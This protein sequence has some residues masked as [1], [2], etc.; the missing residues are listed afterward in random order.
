MQ[1]S[2]INALT[3]IALSACSDQKP[4]NL[5]TAT[6][7]KLGLN[8]VAILIPYHQIPALLT[9]SPTINGEH[10]FVSNEIL[11]QLSKIL[12]SDQ[13]LHEKENFAFGKTGDKAFES[14][15]TAPGK[16]SGESPY[17]LVSTRIDPCVNELQKSANDTCEANI[18]L[19]F[20]PL[21]LDEKGQVFAKDSNIHAIYHIEAKEFTKIVN[22]LKELR[23]KSPAVAQ[24]T[25]SPHPIIAKEG[26]NSPYFHA[27]ISLLQ[28]HLSM[29]NLKRIAF[30]GDTDPTRQGHW[31]M[32]AFNI[33]NQKP[34]LVPLDKLGK[35]D[36]E[37]QKNVQRLHGNHEHLEEPLP[38][39]DIK[40][41]LFP[42]M[43]LTGKE[44]PETIQNSIKQFMLTK[45][46]N[47]FKLDNP[48]LHDP[49]T[50]DCASCHV[51]EIQ[52]SQLLPEVKGLGLELP[53]DLGFRSQHFNLKHNVP[54]DFSR[55]SLQIFSYF[56]NFP[57]ISQRAVNDA[58]HSAELINQIP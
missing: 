53:K 23:A 8:D 46:E 44:D 2:L 40:D 20:Q 12:V 4:S 50:V 37:L 29:Q 7:T 6:E 51:A 55:V 34:V 33:E 56:K 13:A 3:L 48:L 38:R 52:R 32:V 9:K 27:L 21:M 39:G 25:L 30:F 5:S 11:G 28:N 17:R 1:K 54:A 19:V 49:S 26:E 18:R 58:A 16:V 36:G 35:Q 10:T 31:P 45:F 42:V 15:V 14:D 57:K 24:E 47:S 22:E 41:S 43:T